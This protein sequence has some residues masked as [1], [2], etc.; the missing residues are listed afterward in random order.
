MSPAASARIAYMGRPL[1]CAFGM[2][3]SPSSKTGVG[4]GIS[5]PP[6]GL[7]S[8][9]PGFRS[10]PAMCLHRVTHTVVAAGKDQEPRLMGGILAAVAEN[11]QPLLAVVVGPILVRLGQCFH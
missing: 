3:T 6:L 11:Q 9:L 10:Y 7:H 1:P 4:T 5:P 2:T 8:S